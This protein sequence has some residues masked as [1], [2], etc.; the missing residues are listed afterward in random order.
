M[1]LLSSPQSFP[2][3][4]ATAT[5]VL[6]TYD[7]L[8]RIVC[9]D[10]LDRQ[11]M[12]NCAVVCRLGS[13]LALD[14]LWSHSTFD[15]LLRILPCASYKMDS[16][17]RE[18]SV[19]DNFLSIAHWD[20]FFFY[21]KRVKTIEAICF[22]GPPINLKISDRM[23]REMSFSRPDYTLFPNLRKLSWEGDGF[24]TDTWIK[25]SRIFLQTSLSD[26][27]ISFFDEE[28]IA[29][30]ISDI[31]AR[32][33]YLSSL[34]IAVLEFEQPESSVWSLLGLTKI[35]PLLHNLVKLSSQCDAT[36]PESVRAIAK[37]P[38]LSSLRLGLYSQEQDF[39]LLIDTENPFPSL[40]LLEIFRG[41]TRCITQLL[42]KVSNKQAL[43]SLEV[44]VIDYTELAL[45]AFV[46]NLQSACPALQYLTI[47]QDKEDRPVFADSLELARE[48]IPSLPRTMLAFLMGLRE[49]KRL[50]VTY[51]RSSEMTDDDF[52][53]L[54][55]ALPNLTELKLICIPTTTERPALT[56]SVLHRLSDFYHSRPKHARLTNLQLQVDAL[57]WSNETIDALLSSA[58]IYELDSLDVLSFSASPVSSIDNTAL[59]LSHMIP[60]KTKLITNALD[61]ESLPLGS[62][63]EGNEDHEFDVKEMEDRRANWSEVRERIKVFRRMQSI[64]A[65]RKAQNRVVMLL[66]N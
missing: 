47:F 13:D 25:F 44:S 62:T 4:I 39:V 8:E 46:Q 55:A 33:P 17:H 20:R 63:P 24:D 34:R 31:P 53:E 30:F 35:L 7:I 3:L 61:H 27:S 64:L 40:T 48:A 60:P 5:Q 51:Y 49:L 2:T 12:I 54:I 28:I 42:N 14:E 50:H 6:T 19:V 66:P 32:A 22:V 21:S 65:R 59:Y 52:I 37:L 23:L 57:I 16:G 26:L 58:D 36:K 56:L 11:D 38:R 43:T 18:W 45:E 29:D 1:E 15:A 9:L 41:R 10:V